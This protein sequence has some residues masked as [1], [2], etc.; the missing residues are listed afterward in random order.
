M[1]RFIVPRRW[2]KGAWQS[3]IR[4]ELDKQYR[5]EKRVKSV[6][7]T[8]SLKCYVTIAKPIMHDN[9]NHRIE[10]ETQESFLEFDLVPRKCNAVKMEG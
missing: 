4:T 3:S 1:S 2:Q 7:V 8:Q 9:P 5:Y 6:C 10:F